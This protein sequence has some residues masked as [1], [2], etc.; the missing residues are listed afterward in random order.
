MMSM[1]L[2]VMW[3]LDVF[4]CRERWC[5]TAEVAEGT[6]EVNGVESRLGY[7]KACFRRLSTELYEHVTWLDRKTLKFRRVIIDLQCVAG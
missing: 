6:E 3:A 7:G 1:W 5:F 4:G 2:S